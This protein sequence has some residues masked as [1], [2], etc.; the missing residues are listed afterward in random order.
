MIAAPSRAALSYLT[1]LGWVG[2]AVFDDGTVHS[3]PGFSSSKCAR[4]SALFWTSP[5]CAA[6]ILQYCETGQ[7]D[8]VEAIAAALRI[9]LIPHESAMA[10]AEA[11]VRRIDLGLAALKACGGLK[12]LHRR[13]RQ[14]RLAAVA[15]GRHYPAFS[16]I[17]DRLRLALFKRARRRGLLMLSSVTLLS[18]RCSR[19]DQSSVSSTARLHGEESSWSHSTT[20]RRTSRCGAGVLSWALD[21]RSGSA[22]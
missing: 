10:Q 3:V 8:D 13:Y 9:K 7:A 15:A 14:E 11:G 20:T 5:S 22:F 12:L 17:H 19:T 21:I 6:A 16:V 18:T 4:I 1:L 2:I